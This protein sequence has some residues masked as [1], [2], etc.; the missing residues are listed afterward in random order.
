[1]LLGCSCRRLGSGVTTVDSFTWHRSTSF[2]IQFLFISFSIFLFFFHRSSSFTLKHSHYGLG[3]GAELHVELDFIHAVYL[4]AYLGKSIAFH[5]GMSSLKPE[6][7]VPVSGKDGEH[8][9]GGICEVF[10]CFSLDST[11]LLAHLYPKW[12]H[13]GLLDPDCLHLPY[14][15]GFQVL[16]FACRPHGVW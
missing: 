10:F 15:G 1:M 5:G 4:H 2:Q 7:V 6:D 9:P 12:S 16:A 3:L 13:K 14:L 11:Y 8:R